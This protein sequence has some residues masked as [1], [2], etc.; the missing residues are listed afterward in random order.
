MNNPAA[1]V[2]VLRGN[3][4]ESRHEVDI[5]VADAE[6][7]IHTVFGDMDRGVFPRSS[8][9]SLQALPLIESGAAD[10]YGFEDSHLALACASHNGQP[11]HVDAAET[12]LD[13]AGVA[14]TCLECGAQLPKHPEDQAELARTGTI[15][16]AIHNNCS[17]KHAGFLAFAEHAGLEKTGYAGF[18]HPVQ[19]EIAGV[20]EAVTDARHGPDNYGIDGCSIPT[21]EIGLAKLAIAYAKFGIGADKST[22]RSKSMLRLRDACMRHPEMVA[23]D[24]RVCTQLMQ[25]L[26]GRAFVKVGAEGVYT[27]SLPEKGL[28]IAMKA[29]D[30]SFRAV[31]VAVSTLI[32]NLIALSEQEAAAMQA[33]VRPVLHNWN[34]LEVGQLRMAQ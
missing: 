27:A 32:A 19:K 21:Y 11:L 2:E 3:A 8:I 13:R 20:L 25:A 33:L 31:E 22:L 14:A 7:S 24:R 34:G 4:V 10:A 28:G 23:G 15:A 30:G 1:I 6:G 16:T 26:P 29:R 12:M 18:G 9:K 17:G 5:I